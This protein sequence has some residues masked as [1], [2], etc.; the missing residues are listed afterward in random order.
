LDLL[1]AAEALAERLGDPQRLGWIAGYL[2]FSYVAM[3]EYG[4]ALAAGQ[5]ALAL[6][7]SSG[8]FHIQIVAQTN[9]GL[10]YSAVGDFGQTLDLSRRVI[11][12]LTGER[13]Y[14]RVGHVGLLCGVVSRG[15]VAWSLAE[16]G[17]FA[18]GSGVGEEAVQLAFDSSYDVN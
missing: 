2:C 3:G 15:H 17:D 13:R 8:A 18:E 4:R 6:A 16:M 7:T 9:L 5:R 12:S 10:A 11:G 1:R 14:E